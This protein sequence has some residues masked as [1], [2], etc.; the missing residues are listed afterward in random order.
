MNSI[1]LFKGHLYTMVKQRAYL[2]DPDKGV[3]L[4]RCQRCK[5]LSWMEYEIGE[6]LQPKIIHTERLKP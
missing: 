2:C 1:C 6:L 3:C 5:T 4:F